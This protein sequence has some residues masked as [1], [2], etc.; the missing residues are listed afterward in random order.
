MKDKISG[1]LPKSGKKEKASNIK[2]RKE[3]H[4]VVR[5]LII[6]SWGALVAFAVCYALRK[7]GF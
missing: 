3:L 1:I 4:P 5:I 2:V 7:A 6:S